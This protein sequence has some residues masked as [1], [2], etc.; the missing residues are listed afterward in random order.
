MAA[1]LPEP[2]S[3][4]TAHEGD[5]QTLNTHAM[6][7]FHRFKNFVRTTLLGATLALLTADIARATWYEQ[8]VAGVTE[9]VLPE[10]GAVDTNWNI[11]YCS[12][13]SGKLYAIYNPSPGANWTGSPLVTNI[14][15]ITYN[16]MACDPVNHWTFY[17]GT[18][19]YIWVIYWNGSAWSSAK[20]GSNVNHGSQLCV[21]SVYHCLW[22][23]D[24]S[25][26]L[27]LLY[28]NGSTWVETKIDGTNQKYPSSR[29]C[30]V[31]STWHIAWYLTLDRKS[32]RGTY[33]N[34]SGWTN[35]VPFGT[36][37][38]AERYVS[39]CCQEST[40]TPF[41][42]QDNGSGTSTKGGYFYWSGSA[43][44]PATCFQDGNLPTPTG[45]CVVSPNPYSCLFARFSINYACYFTGWSAYARN[46]TSC[47]HDN[48]TMSGGLLPLACGQDGRAILCRPLTGT[49]VKMLFSDVP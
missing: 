30:G 38:G 31:D 16:N 22:Y 46:W 5:L 18:D 36:L 14:N 8:P 19:D 29:A 12:G 2:R 1:V 49:G 15:T 6:K 4:R 9:Q 33:W 44:T 3:Q 23:L 21:D 32:L 20:V 37:P 24:A 48:A 13:Y 45:F 47:R 26:H 10:S 34:G 28:W 39:L 42:W 7:P 25:F 27:W 41:N 40:H 11:Y 35:G 43:W 17:T